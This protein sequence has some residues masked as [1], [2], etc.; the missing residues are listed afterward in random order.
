MGAC[1]RDA[2]SRRK[3][4]VCGTKKSLMGRRPSNNNNHSLNIAY[5]CHQQRLN[6]TFFYPLQNSHMPDLVHHIHPSFRSSLIPLF[7]CSNMSGEPAKLSDMRVALFQLEAI[8]ERI[9]ANEYIIKD[10]VNI[11]LQ[12]MV[13]DMTSEHKPHF[14]E[15]YPS[16]PELNEGETRWT[17]RMLGRRRYLLHETHRPNVS[18]RNSTG[19]IYSWY[20][21]GQI[22]WAL[23]DYKR[24]SFSW[25]DPMKVHSSD[26]RFTVLAIT[27]L[28][29][30]IPIGYRRPVCSKGIRCLH[31]DR[32]GIKKAS[33][34]QGSCLPQPYPV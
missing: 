24:V 9:H 22:R 29:E 17:P 18:A 26:I 19:K 31:N 15:A 8:I 10:G 7:L 20:V 5:F 23:V 11:D 30:C 28:Q 3:R 34:Y 12:H 27:R 2:A 6:F 25:P 1:G 21:M 33:A 32:R 16:L 14:F 13:L 4:A